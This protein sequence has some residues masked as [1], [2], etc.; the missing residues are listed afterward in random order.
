MN[1]SLNKIQ[2]SYTMLTSVDDS[3]DHVDGLIGNNLKERE[4]QLTKNFLETR[5]PGTTN[6]RNPVLTKAR[7]FRYRRPLFCGII[8]VRGYFLRGCSFGRALFCRNLGLN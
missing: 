4:C 8:F 2:S 1:K 3:T 7:D 6:L 5:V